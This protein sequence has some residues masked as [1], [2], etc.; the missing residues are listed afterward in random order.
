MKVVKVVSPMHQ[1]P[2]P[3]RRYLWYS[4]LLEAE[5]TP[6]LSQRKI[7][8]TTQGIKPMTIQLV[9]HCLNQLHHHKPPIKILSKKNCISFKVYYHASLYT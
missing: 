3:P 2:L 6:G 1:P 4:F 7:P 9:A 8:M 5:L